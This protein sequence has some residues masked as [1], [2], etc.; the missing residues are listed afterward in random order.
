MKKIIRTTA[1][2][3]TLLLI[4]TS[5]KLESRNQNVPN[6]A[7]LHNSKISLDWWGLYTGVLPCADCE[8]IKVLLTLNRDE[9][10]EL[11]FTY[12]G[13]SEIPV[14]FTGT[15]AWDETGGKITVRRNNFPIRYKVGEGRLFQ[16]DLE[17]NPISGELADMYILTKVVE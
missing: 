17:G 2:I 7:T 16:L 3:A 15:F 14:V 12:I 10:Y 1:V 6:L 4:L 11:S 8:G 5:C 13:K 9:T